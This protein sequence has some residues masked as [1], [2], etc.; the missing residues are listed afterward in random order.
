[1]W[2]TQDCAAL[3]ILNSGLNDQ[4]IE[5]II[6]QYST[7][8]WVYVGGHSNIAPVDSH[9]FNESDSIINPFV[10]AR[11]FDLMNLRF[12]VLGG[13]IPVDVRQASVVF[14]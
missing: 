11:W 9:V 14:V 4:S 12:L 7:N 1:M 8:V 6:A 13:K 10:S 5:V 3:V 2:L